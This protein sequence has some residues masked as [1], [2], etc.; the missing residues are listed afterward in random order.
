[1]STQFQQR[2]GMK[3]KRNA[4]AA[5]AVVCAVAVGGSSSALAQGSG[6]SSSQARG[7]RC[8]KVIERIAQHLG[9]STDQVKAAIKA[10]AFARIDEAVK[11]GRMSQERATAL[12]AKIEANICAALAG[13][14]KH[15]AAKH[16]PK[17][18]LR[19]AGVYLGLSGAQ[20]R[21]Q[22]PGT[23]LAALAAKQPG[24]SAAGLKAAMVAPGKAKLDK[25]LAEGK[26]DAAR[27]AAALEKLVKL[28]DRLAEKVW[29]KK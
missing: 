24:K 28:A 21:A 7:E 19:A 9:M 20:L 27:H 12:K 25:A 26:I 5:L 14:A 10:R 18:M 6:K 3:L 2:R 11:S 15:Q 23:S 17:G 4:I 29:P 1:M 13:M 22:L 16:A 8:E